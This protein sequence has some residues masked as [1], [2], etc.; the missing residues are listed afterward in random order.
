MEINVLNFRLNLALI[1]FRDLFQLCVVNDWFLTF[2]RCFKSIIV[3]AIE[4]P[5]LGPPWGPSVQFLQQLYFQSPTPR[6]DSC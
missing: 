4:G 3:L 2:R 5:P 1:F 6:D